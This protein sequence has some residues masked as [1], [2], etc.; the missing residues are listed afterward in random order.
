MRCC[1]SPLEETFYNLTNVQLMMSTGCNLSCRYC[2]QDDKK[3]KNMSKEVMESFIDFLCDTNPDVPVL[4]DFFGGEPLVNWPVM[5]YGL[6]LMDDLGLTKNKL[7][8]MVS[9]NGT[10]ITDEIAEYFRKYNVHI[11][12]SIDGTPEKH[13]YERN[14]SYDKTI[15]GLHKLYDHGLCRDIT[16][17]LTFPNNYF[18]SIEE[19]VRSV[20]NLGIPEVTFAAVLAG[21]ITDEELSTYEESMYRT[22][23]LILKYV[24]YGLAVI[25]KYMRNFIMMEHINQDFK[26]RQPCHFKTNRGIVVDTDGVL[27]GC[28]IVPNSDFKE[29]SSKVYSD[30]VVGNVKYGIAYN[31]NIGDKYPCTTANAKNDCINCEAKS[32]C[33]PCAMENMLSSTR[34]YHLVADDKCKLI[35]ARYRVA[36]RIHNW[37]LRNKFGSVA[38]SR[39]KENHLL[40][41]D[42]YSI[43]SLII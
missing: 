7:Y 6:D 24:E 35:K 31:R 33:L 38:M 26:P 27:F 22:A 32:M 14:N 39:L 4:I 42:K 23:I 19:H 37:I 15:E 1:I 18:G 9:T 3:N 20:L 36:L 21:G 29:Y 41:E 13:N 8:F 10:L 25:P 5:K 12:I 17:R 16:A 2:Y 34:D 28:S 43:S 30:T 11:N 40:G